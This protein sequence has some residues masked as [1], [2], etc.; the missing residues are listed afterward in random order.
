MIFFPFFSHDLRT[1]SRRIGKAGEDDAVRLLVRDGYSI[2]ARNFQNYRAELDIIARDGGTIV[3]VEVKTRYHRKGRPMPEP[4]RNLTDRQKYRIYRAALAYLH[5]NEDKTQ[6]MRYRFDF[7][8]IIRTW[9]S[10]VSVKHHIDFIGKPGRVFGGI[11]S[12][13]W[14][15]HKNSANNIEED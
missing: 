9:S 2:L 7:I 11:P 13:V 6:G 10:P 12:R 1:W 5:E 8:E 14:V 15:R 3:F 4:W